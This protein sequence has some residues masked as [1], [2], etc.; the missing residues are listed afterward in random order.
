MA[1]NLGIAPGPFTAG[2]V[3]PDA[4]GLTAGQNGCCEQCGEPFSSTGPRMADLA[5]LRGTHARDQLHRV[6]NTP[7]TMQRRPCTR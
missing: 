1:Q 4:G 2:Q 5:T 7:S 3:A 6:T